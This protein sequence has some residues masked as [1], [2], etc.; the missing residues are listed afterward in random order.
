MINKNIFDIKGRGESQIIDLSQDNE[1]TSSSSG[2]SALTATP[3]FVSV[4]TKFTSSGGA[5]DKFVSANAL[6]AGMGL[7]W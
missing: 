5:I 1:E 6:G 3:T 4:G 7:A 2:F